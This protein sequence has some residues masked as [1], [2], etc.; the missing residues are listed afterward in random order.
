MTRSVFA[1]A[2]LLALTGISVGQSDG[3]TSQDIVWEASIRGIG[4]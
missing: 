4:G 1:L 3:G 2:A